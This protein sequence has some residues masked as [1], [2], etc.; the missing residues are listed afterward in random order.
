MKH[1]WSLLVVLSLQTPA[2][3]MDSLNEEQLAQAVGQ[4]GI[5][6]KILPASKTGTTLTP[7]KIG[8][9][10]VRWTDKDGI[11]SAING[12]T[13]TQSGGLVTNM[14]A[15]SGL[16]FCTNTTGACAT[17]SQPMTLTMDMDGAGNKPKQAY[18]LGVFR[19]ANDLK[20]IHFDIDSIG[21]RAGN[22][23]TNTPIATLSN[24]I[25]LTFAGTGPAG[26]NFSFGGPTA[27]G[28]DYDALVNLVNFNLASLDLGTVSLVSS[29]GQT[30][31]SSLRFG[32]KVT[33]LDLSGS[34]MDLSAAGLVLSKS[35]LGK[36]NVEVNNIEAGVIGNQAAGT[37]DNLKNGSLGSVGM[38]GIQLTNP[39]FTIKGL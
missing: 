18:L 14:R 23:A 10:A 17:S 36:F 11:S 7:G 39:R 38:T 29:G 8:L 13:Y 16:W 37:F 2:W 15:N 33:N 5:T 6:I 25:N 4:D 9:N 27:K 31:E 26:M 28:T 35:T 20:R 22:S 30:G 19:L 34:N 1:M 32:A 3:A 24:G 21:L 12:T